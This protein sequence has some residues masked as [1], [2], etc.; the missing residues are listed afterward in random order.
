[1]VAIRKRKIGKKEYFYL[2]HTIKIDGKVK[3]K[4]KYLGKKVPKEIEKVKQNFF[5]EIFKEKWFK[6]LDRIK[7]NFSKDYSLMPKTAKKKYI[8]NFMIT[9]TY[10]TNRIEGSTL[11][12]KETAR[13]LERGI[14]PKKPIEDVKETEA[15][16]EVFYEMMNH[17]KDLNLD[18]VLYW[19]M[20]LFKN[21]KQDIAG[22]IRKH[23]VGV[24]GSKAE[25]PFAAELN[26]LLKEFF[27]WFHKN[28]KKLHPVELAALVHLKFVSIHPFSDGNG[29]ISRLIM[30]FILHKAKYPMLNIHYSNRDSYYT[31]LERAQLNE[32]DYIFARYLIKRYIK[33][34][35]NLLKS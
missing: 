34:Y 33:E 27:R 11:S 18:V 26:I 14:T 16:K 28:K 24:A 9:F 25:F 3:K 7:S 4:E 19:H 10:D 12:L 1:M 23:S 32:K 5:H 6:S 2:E 15:H 8:Q 21:T 35:N 22:K 20:L 13:L 17:Q 30:N 29:R 31:A